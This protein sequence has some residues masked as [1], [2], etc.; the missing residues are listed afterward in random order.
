MDKKPHEPGT[1]D[2]FQ[3]LG[4]DYPLED[5]DVKG[6]PRPHLVEGSN[7]YENATGEPDNAPH[8]RPGGFEVPDDDLA[9]E[10]WTP[11]TRSGG[12]WEHPLE[13]PLE[14]QLDQTEG[15]ETEES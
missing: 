11:P 15:T 13:T 3:P 5:T 14:E 7:A 12:G 6:E 2:D 4:K 9:G 8:R 10:G 1:P